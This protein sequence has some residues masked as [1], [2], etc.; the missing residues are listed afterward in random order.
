M[1]SIVLGPAS[2]PDFVTWATMNTGTLRFLAYLM[3][4][5]EHSLICVRLPA[6]DS[7]DCEYMVCIESIMM[8]HGL[9]LSHAAM[10]FSILVSGYM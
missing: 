6:T 5:P 4:W 8:K 1:C 10:M 2:S 3:S 7:A 9:M